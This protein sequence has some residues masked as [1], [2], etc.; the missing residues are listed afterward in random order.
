MGQFSSSLGEYGKGISTFLTWDMSYFYTYVLLDKNSDRKAL[1][2]KMQNY[3]Q[4]V[5][6]ES[7]K[8]NKYGLQP[9]SQIYL[10]SDSYLNGY[11]AFRAGSGNE[12]KYYWSIS[13]IILLISMT[14]YI[15]LIRGAASRRYHELGARKVVGA[16]PNTI[17]KQII[18][19]SNLTTLLSL[20]PAS[21]V[22]DSGISLIN[23]TMNRT[24]TL[25]VFSNPLMWILLIS[26]VIITGT[27]SGLAISYKISRIP[28]LILLSGKSSEKS[29]SRKWNNSF[30]ILHFS[31]YLI[32]VVS[33]IGVSK[34]IKY[35]RTSIKGINP[36]NIMIS[37]LK[38]PALKA[39]FA[40]ICSEM[41]KVP[42]VE[43]IAGS[44]FIPFFS[45]YIPLT[46]A[47]P[48][49]EK[50]TLDGLIMGEGMTELLGM[51]ILEGSSF[52]KF[53][54]TTGEALFNESSAKKYN[55]KVGDIY[56]N[57]FHVKG[58]VQ[59]FH[60]HSLHTLIQP[61]VIIQQNPALMELL[62]IK[63]NGI[64][65]AAII[66][67]LREMYLQISPDEIFEINYL[68]DEI[69]N[70]YTPEKNQAE[71]MGAFS[72]LAAILATIGL[73]GIALNSIA[74]KK[75]EIGLRKV[76]GASIIELIFMLNNEFLRW[77]IVSL[78]VGI[79]ISL[80]L[81]TNWQKRFAYKTDLSWW[82]FAVAG[83]S[84]I[85]IAVLTVSWQSWRA[86]TRNPIEALRYE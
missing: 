86:A 34:Q 84:A 81:M 55:L 6:Y 78:L 19:E 24:L 50:I 35:S 40:A 12:L 73:F 49:G 65:D 5:S 23:N 1:V 10:N 27:I 42:G 57:A 51:K 66:K 47:N 8:M 43:K 82:I 9:V 20:I 37:W 48:Q 61:M 32:L 33:V 56:L 3:S 71:I 68:T 60:S 14:S 13:L 74:K 28:A 64:N 38:S 58:I 18:L 44:S 11:R 69:N 62:A 39:S 36:D 29:A 22:I 25:D 4:L 80:Y 46:L 63:T 52:G 77:V 2:A 83:V 21:F 53:N 41:E 45:P 16:S 70:I 59:D 75:K 31:T 7:G 30:L 26:V 79:P 17:L 85:L 76:N 54:L 15:F 67:K 72:L